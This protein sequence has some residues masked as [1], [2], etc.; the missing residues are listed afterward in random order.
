MDK[1]SLLKKL[2]K[3][4][5]DKNLSY[6]MFRTALMVITIYKLYGNFQY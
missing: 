4:I 3:N 2:Q 1:E 5:V 6:F